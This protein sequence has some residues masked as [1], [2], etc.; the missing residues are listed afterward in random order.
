MKKVIN[1]TL[2]GIVFAIDQDAFD[3]LESYLSQ[4]KNNLSNSTDAK[5]VVEDIESAIAE[6]FI[7][8]KR[9]EKLAVT[10]VDVSQVMHEMGSP[11]D[12]GEGEADEGNT[13]AGQTATTE[14]K[15]RLYRDT[16]DA[17]IAGVAS[18]LARYFDIDPVIVR[19]IF[20]VSIFFNGLGVLAY[21]VLWLVVPTAKTTADKYAMRGEQVTLKEISER[22]KKNIQGI[23][24]SDLKK[25]KGVWTNIRGLLDRLFKI[26]GIIVRVVVVA[27]RYL[28]GIVL[29]VGGALGMAGMA[30]IYSVILLSDKV[31]FPAN[32]QIALDT[33]QA[34]TLGIVTMV[35]LF[36]MLSVP[37]IALIAAG[38]SFLA[39][40]NFF[41]VQKTVAL[42][43]VWIV[44][45]AVAG[46]TLALQVERVMQKTGP[47]EGRFDDSSFEVQWERGV[48]YGNDHNVRFIYKD[49]NA[50]TSETN[51]QTVLEAQ[52]Q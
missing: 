10:E 13:S 40:Q 39:K 32:V 5:E 1:I 33:L 12:F 34:G 24:E 19:L 51:N 52:P 3:A 25:A 26:L 18:G 28:V 6:K 23:E 37:L 15:K 9:S 45:T 14:P 50:T 27:V 46:T 4:I 41:T 16:D 49:M 44:A 21:I 42:A 47:I 22:V 7:V 8:R 20:V 31:L 17:I 11:A 2:G 29:V 30:S 48:I 35:S 38:A 43:V 36:I